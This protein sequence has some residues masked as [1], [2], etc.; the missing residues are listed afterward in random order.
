MNLDTSM[1]W[2]G[3]GVVEAVFLIQR[4]S[5]V[6]LQIPDQ[7]SPILADLSTH[8]V[9]SSCLPCVMEIRIRKTKIGQCLEKLSRTE[10]VMVMAC[11]QCTISGP[12]TVKDQTALIIR[13]GVCWWTRPHMGPNPSSEKVSRSRGGRGSFQC[14]LM[15]VTFPHL[16][17]VF[18]EE[19]FW[20][21][22]LSDRVDAPRQFILGCYLCSVGLKVRKGDYMAGLLLTSVCHTFQFLALNPSVN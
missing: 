4:N 13:G 20:P 2:E 19:C 3:Q 21:I 8:Q 10:I 12:L 6:M 1:L 7:R 9:L 11:R 5:T 22:L 14:Y 16:V 17:K 15:F 18:H